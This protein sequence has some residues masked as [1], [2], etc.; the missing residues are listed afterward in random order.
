VDYE[1]LLKCNS[2][3]AIDPQDPATFPDGIIAWEDKD[4]KVEVKG[5]QILKDRVAVLV[6]MTSP[7]AATEVT[8]VKLERNG[9]G[10]TITTCSK[11][12][13]SS[14]TLTRSRKKWL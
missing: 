13:T 3:V 7:E 11:T 14:A 12:L 10:F 5:T 2:I 8:D 9:Q 4:V 6:T 1:T